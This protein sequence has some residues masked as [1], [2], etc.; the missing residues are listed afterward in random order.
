MLWVSFRTPGDVVAGAEPIAPRKGGTALPVQTELRAEVCM[1]PFGVFYATRE[2]QTA[3]IAAHVSERLENRG[4]RV[5]IRNLRDHPDLKI[6]DYEAVIL[7]S[8]VHAGN[9]DPSIT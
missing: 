6:G 1:K 2:G 5:Q 3:R 8:P 4:F 7:A 9:H